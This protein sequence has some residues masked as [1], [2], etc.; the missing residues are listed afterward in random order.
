MYRPS[1]FDESPAACRDPA[2]VL[3]QDDRTEL[4]DWQQAQ[5]HVEHDADFGASLL[6]PDREELA[7]WEAEQ[8]IAPMLSNWTDEQLAQLIGLAEW[9]GTTV[10]VTAATAELAKRGNHTHAA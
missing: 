10:F 1:F 8:A 4:S 5:S 3:A 6:E 7:Q 2:P 9:T